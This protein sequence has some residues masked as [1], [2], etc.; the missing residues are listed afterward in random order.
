MKV[1]FKKCSFIGA[2]LMLLASG[3]FPVAWADAI[4][5][6][7]TIQMGINDEGHLN[8][9]GGTPSFE[10]NTAAV[11]LRFML[12]NS[13][14]TAPGCLCEGWG[15]ADKISGISGYANE[16]MG[17]ANVSVTSFVSDHD[18]ATSTVEIKDGTGLP[19]MEVTHDYQPST[20]TRNLYDVTVTIKNISSQVI[21]P[22]YRRVMD[23]DIA[24]TTFS[25]YST[26]DTGNAVELVNT[27]NDGFA[28]ANPLGPDTSGSVSPV[29]HGSFTDEGPRDHGA[30]FDFHFEELGPGDSKTF[31]TF[32]GAASDEMSAI[33][34]LSAVS[35]E[36]YSFGQPR[37]DENGIPVGDFSLARPD[38]GAPNTFIFAFSG[39]GGDPVF[40]S[41]TLTPETGEQE[42]EHEY[43]L[44]ATLLDNEGGPVVD[45][46]VLFERTGANPGSESLVSDSA[47]MALHC[48][49]GTLEGLDTVVAS[50]GVLSD[51]A[52]VTWKR[53]VHPTTLFAYPIVASVS[54]PSVRDIRIRLAPKAK[55]IDQITSAPVGGR[56]IRFSTGNTA[57][58]SAVTNSLGI[59]TCQRTIIGTIQ[60]V[61]RFGYDAR[62]DGDPSFTGS[63][64]RGRILSVTLGPIP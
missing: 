4:I 50:S 46:P 13:E 56:T 12:N 18:S 55:L 47:G 51:T 59:A 3:L 1:Q 35:A 14:A 29:L 64:A 16:A 42:V 19:V 2:A 62:F 33:A 27:T 24:P 7:G 26:I 44:T 10:S 45:T 52:T 17:T 57:I 11:G 8:V 34:A 37:T 20:V 63:T 25:E 15:A 41:L 53:T 60:S 32:Y 21:D 30:L 54:I 9:P 31:T 48:W 43:C 6:N 38:I 49:T 23:W 5:D 39:V 58:C 22:V 36:A 40:S 28:T 61:L